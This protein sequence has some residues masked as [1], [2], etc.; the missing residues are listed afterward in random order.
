METRYAHKIGG[1]DEDPIRSF[2]EMVYPTS[3]HS[4]ITV[5]YNYAHFPYVAVKPTLI[6]PNP[7]PL[8]DNGDWLGLKTVHKISADRSYSDW[9]M[10][11]D[12]DPFNA[13]GPANNWTLAA[14]ITTSVV[15][16]ITISR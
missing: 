3:S 7:P 4:N 15:Q 1:R 2:I 14:L 8:A 12:V 11:I 13:N 10:Y 16:T 9:E 5:N 6:I